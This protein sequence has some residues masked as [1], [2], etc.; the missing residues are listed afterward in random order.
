MGTKL[1]H[2]GP[3][4]YPSPLAPEGLPVG[5]IEGFRRAQFKGLSSG[6]GVGLGLPLVYVELTGMQVSSSP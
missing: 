6:Q 1:G 3:V 2:S 5:F 4:S